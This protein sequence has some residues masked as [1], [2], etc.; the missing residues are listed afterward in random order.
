MIKIATLPQPQR[1]EAPPQHA[2]AFGFDSPRWE[3]AVG[4]LFGFLCFMPYLAIPAGANTAIQLGNIIT[5]FAIAPVFF[6]KDRRLPLWIFLM[7]MAP[8]WISCIKVGF[9]DRDGDVAVSVK[10]LTIFLMS[11]CTIVAAQRLTPRH[12]LAL[13]TGIAIATIVHAIVGA[14][15]VYNFSTGGDLP[16]KW[17]YVNPSFLS[18]QEN[19]DIISRYTRRPFGLFPEPS[20]MS[21]SLAPW[22]LFW[23]AQM[24][25][26]VTLKLKPARWQRILFAV[27]AAGGLGLII[28]SQSGHAAV[29]LVGVVLLVGIWFVRCRATPATFLAVAMV[30]GVAMPI[31]LYFGA[32][33]LSTRLGGSSDLGNSSWEDRTE[34][35][36]IGYSLLVDRNLPTIIFGIGF[37]QAS[38]QLQRTARLEAVWS[39]TLTYVYETGLLGLAVL[40]WIGV[41]VLR[42]WNTGGRSVVFAIIF[43]V[44]IVG[45]T[46]TT[47]YESLLPV[48]LAIGWLTMWPTLCEPPVNWNR[49][50]LAPKPAADPIVHGA[51]RK[52]KKARNASQWISQGWR[53]PGSD[54]PVLVPAPAQVLPAPSARWSTP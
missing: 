2:S 14:W 15:Q 47:S 11:V 38:P 3:A 18:V 49:R 41:Y 39:V 20:A 10:T 50:N 30:F 23:I 40:L 27:A 36:R 5:F 28:A 31:T 4:G 21:S 37:G 29:T 45:V 54:L 7:F 1:I 6:A 24:C 53:E 17:F 46:L 26:I 22:V 52:T 44:W 16:M 33:E 48:W 12:A 42:Q 35:L 32:T 34:S 51:D 43:F 25:G 9:D 19:A 8:A 13:M